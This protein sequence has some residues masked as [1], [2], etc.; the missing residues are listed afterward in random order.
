[1]TATSQ[2][3]RKTFIKT[4]GG[5]YEHS[6]WIAEMTWD[7]GLTITEDSAKGLRAAMAD[8]I[9]AAG[10]E[11]Q[12]ALLRAHPDLAGKLAI[13]GDLTDDSTS[14]QASAGLD[15]CSPN[16]FDELQTLNTRYTETFNFPYILA[17]KGRDVP[18]ILENFRSRVG[19]DAEVEFQE[20]LQ[21]VHQI[22]L[23]RLEALIG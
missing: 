10:R 6:D 1:M 3:D 4:F 15:K 18:E 13:N 14:E 23:L 17:V 7:K 8:I 22:A 21:Q 19:N 5:V 12:L 11:P 16:E 9:E 20:A 2:M